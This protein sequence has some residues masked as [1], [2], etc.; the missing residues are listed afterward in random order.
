MNFLRSAASGVAVYN[1]ALPLT[2]AS[3]VFIVLALIAIILLGNAKWTAGFVFLFLSIISGAVL[4][5]MYYGV[6]N[7]V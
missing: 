6:T 2:I 5:F 7:I 1:S 4:Y 3:I